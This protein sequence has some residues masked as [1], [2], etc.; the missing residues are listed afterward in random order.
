MTSIHFHPCSK[1]ILRV[2]WRPVAP[3]SSASVSTL[4]P[5][6]RP[7]ISLEL[8]QRIKWACSASNRSHRNRTM[9]V[10]SAQQ[11]ASAEKVRLGIS[12][13]SQR[14]VLHARWSTSVS[15]FPSSNMH[16]VVCRHSLLSAADVLERHLR[17]LERDPTYF[18]PAWAA[19]HAL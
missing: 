2:K 8:P 16:S 14:P 12:A 19:S 6:T 3:V 5:G 18:L 10:V 9:T 17:S 13:R 11:E 15:F 7:S 4:T 1:L